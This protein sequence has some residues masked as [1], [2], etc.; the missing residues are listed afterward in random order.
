M[1]NDS[2]KKVRYMTIRDI[3]AASGM[4]QAALCR[5]FEIPRRTLQNWVLGEREAPQYVLNMIA[6]LLGIK[7]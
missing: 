3:L 5:R 7:E 1:I 4:T 2:G 6:E